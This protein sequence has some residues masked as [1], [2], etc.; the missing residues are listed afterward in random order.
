MRQLLAAA[1]LVTVPAA[2]AGGSDPSE[3]EVVEDVAAQ[4]VE[5]GMEQEAADCFAAIVVEEVGVDVIED[6]DFSADEPPAG[7]GEDL[8]AAAQRAAEDCD[9]AGAGSG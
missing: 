5:T 7:V 8:V 1:L 6:V 4:L 3:A 2:C 9:L